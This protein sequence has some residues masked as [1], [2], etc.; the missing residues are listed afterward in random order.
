MLNVKTG[1][2]WMLTKP[3]SSQMLFGTKTVCF[4]NIRSRLTCSLSTVKKFTVRSFSQLHKV[5]PLKV[6][7]VISNSLTYQNLET[8]SKD[9]LNCEGT[10]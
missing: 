9:K 6:S 8:N 2:R 7:S 3:K 4:R 5:R 10:K 1:K